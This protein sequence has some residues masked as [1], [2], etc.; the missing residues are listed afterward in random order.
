MYLEQTTPEGEARMLDEFTMP[1]VHDIA[2]ANPNVVIFGCTSAAA[3]RGRVYEAE[4]CN[5]I[6]E[7]TGVPTISV[8]NSVRQS[9]RRLGAR[10]VAVVTPYSAVLNDRIKASLEGDNLEVVALHGLGI[11]HNFEIAGVR[12]D[13]I[14]AFTMENVAS[15]VKDCIFISCTNFRG[16][17]AVSAL[18]EATEV[19]VVTSNLA[20]LETIA[21]HL[22]ASDRGG[23]PSRNAAA[24]KGV[25]V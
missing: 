8:M 20:V 5:S 6:T 18:R 22:A 1:A 19:P 9:I 24:A 23:P 7:V 4:L 3:L 12:P 13:H 25:P 16:W 21:R 15:V 10:K 17:E 2:T 14:A 11:T